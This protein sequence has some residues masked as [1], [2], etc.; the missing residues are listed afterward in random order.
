MS[1]QHQEGT[2]MC[3]FH[4]WQASAETVA[5]G[6]VRRQGKRP[7]TSF[8]YNYAPAVC[9]K[10]GQKPV[11]FFPVIINDKPDWAV[12]LVFKREG[13]AGP[14]WYSNG[15]Y[16]IDEKRINLADGDENPTRPGCFLAKWFSAADTQLFAARLGLLFEEV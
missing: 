13:K 6:T 15:V 12:A 3:S 10:C 8:K 1:I 11:R 7:F 16:N 2:A 9:P 5:C 14:V 4:V